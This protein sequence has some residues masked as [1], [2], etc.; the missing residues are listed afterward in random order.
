[1]VFEE[2]CS[3]KNSLNL[4]CRQGKIWWNLELDIEPLQ[5]ELKHGVYHKE[6]YNVRKVFQHILICN[7][8]VCK[9]IKIQFFRH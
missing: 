9:D 2:V 5:A 8:E 7:Y 4:Y 6:A 3:L 1:M